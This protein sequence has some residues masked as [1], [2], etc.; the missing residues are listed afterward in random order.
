M[1]LDASKT[2]LIIEQLTVFLLDDWR[3]LRDIAT[4]D[5]SLDKVWL[6]AISNRSTIVSVMLLTTQTFDS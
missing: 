2:V 3:W 1:P 6:Q 5:M 4:K